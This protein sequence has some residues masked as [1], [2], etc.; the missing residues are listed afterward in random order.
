MFDVGRSSFNKNVAQET[1][2]KEDPLKQLA[3]ADPDIAKTVTNALAQ[4]GCPVSN[5]SIALLVEET[6][7]GLVLDFFRSNISNR[8]CESDWGG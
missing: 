4:K 5:K 6:L 7:W 3:I 8:L 2:H 1:M